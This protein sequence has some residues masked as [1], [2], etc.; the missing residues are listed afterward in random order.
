LKRS[1]G[2]PPSKAVCGKQFYD[3]GC[4]VLEFLEEVG[5]RREK[6][7]PPQIISLVIL[8]I[9]PAPLLSKKDRSKCHDGF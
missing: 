6:L 4:R 8:L 5:T 7:F 1:R 9:Q 3:N 2:V